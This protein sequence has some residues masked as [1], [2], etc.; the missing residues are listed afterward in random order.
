M[1]YRLKLTLL[2][3]ASKAVLSSRQTV[4]SHSALALK[5]KTLGFPLILASCLCSGMSQAIAKDSSDTLANYDSSMLWGSSA[6]QLNLLR[7]SEGNPIDAGVHSIDMSVNDSPVGRF[8][9]TF[10]AGDKPGRAIACLNRDLLHRAGIDVDKLT[11]TDASQCID[12]SSQI[13]GATYTFDNNEQRLTLSIPQAFMDHTPRGYVSPELWSNGINAA[14][15]DYSV[16]GYQS[17]TDG[18][19]SKNVYASLNTGLNL[20]AWRLRQRSAVNWA[21]DSGT[22][23]QALSTYAQRD[24]DFLRSQLT[25]GDTFT[26]GELFDSVAT[27]GVRLASDDRMLPDSQLGYAPVVRGIAST[28]ARVTIRQN[29]FI[30]HESTVSPGAFEIQDLNPTSDS[31]D[32]IVTVT[33]ADGR[34]NTF[35]VPFSS[36]ARSLRP[37]TSRYTVTVGQARNL[38]YNDKP[39]VAQVTY[40][41]G[42]TNLIT[43]YTGTS[44]AEG[45]TSVLIGSVLNT[46]YG[47]LGVDVTGARTQVGNQTFNGQSARVTYNKLMQTTGTNFTVAAYRY[48]TDGYFG[49]VD[50]LTAR[51]MLGG[52]GQSQAA[53]ESIRHA[54]SRVDLNI[55]QNVGT[56]S[57]VYINVSQQSYWNQGGNDTQLQTGLTNNWNWGNTTVSAARTKDIYGRADT[58]YL[59]SI[60]VPIGQGSQRPYLTTSASHNTNGANNLNSTLNGI[61]GENDQIGYGVTASHDTSN[62]AETTTGV[63]G[64]GQ[65][66]TSFGILNGSVSHSKNYQQASAGMNGSVVAHSGGVVFGQTLGDSIAVISAPGA[67]GA[68]VTNSNNV[69]LDG[70]GQAVVPYLS[71]YRV[72]SLAID[73]IGLSDD[74]ELKSTSQDIVP[75]SGA[76]MLVKF[77]AVSGRALLIQSQ[78]ANGKPLPF[79][80]A[81]LD[82]QNREVGAVGQGGQIFARLDGDKGSLHINLDS[83]ETKQC[84]IAFDLKP[85]EKGKLSSKLETLDAPCR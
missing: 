67:D 19:T 9:I 72:N 44:A 18:Q 39:T 7:Y 16:N 81:V 33:E 85:R 45:Y 12:L 53:A 76:V 5:L 52:F 15:I 4:K 77:E 62:T 80:A 75:R 68:K 46:E 29:G 22:N 23:S 40:Q 69:S 14:F 66:R 82:E 78:Q 3:L 73:P 10:I 70:S 47:A 36:V 51:D 25:L 71:S 37:G 55:S 65:Y 43:G 31:G 17:D 21:E 64:N 60:S 42:L 38:A 28:N 26:D 2:T 74:V 24:V 41:R 63:G 6:Q 84:V 20:G 59:L 57:S 35:V 61:A 13:A 27:R 50:A 11:V 83:K 79:G 54:R 8:D 49:L 1:R 34:A 56:E 48:S 58:Q 30:I 32:L